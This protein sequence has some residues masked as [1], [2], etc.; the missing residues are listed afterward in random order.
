M[1]D[2]LEQARSARQ[3]LHS[4]E[5]L[6]LDD[7]DRAV[8]DLRRFIEQRNLSESRGVLD[9]YFILR[10]ISQINAPLVLLSDLNAFHEELKQLLVVVREEVDGLITLLKEMIENIA[11]VLT[12]QND[13]LKSRALGQMAE[14]QITMQR[15]EQKRGLLI[16]FLRAW[17]V[18]DTPNEWEPDTHSIVLHIPTEDRTLNSWKDWIAGVDGLFVLLLAS[19]ERLDLL[20]GVRIQRFE[21]GSFGISLEVGKEVWEHILA[22]LYRL[23]NA[24]GMELDNR[25]KETHGIVGAAN[26][27]AGLNRQL[28]A[29]EI[30]KDA[31]RAATERIAAIHHLDIAAYTIEVDGQILSD[32][33]PIPALN[34]PKE[35][36]ALPPGKKSRPRRRRGGK[37]EGTASGG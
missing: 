22:A 26:A 21:A 14:I 36:L 12:A 3:L 15:L 27:M 2:A 11:Q 4:T 5:D 16:S 20:D 34:P 24:R 29:G 30:G 37:P 33:R 35:Q 25:E 1:L 17:E 28:A 13:N 18:F 19:E 23:S 9:S 10:E 31:H 7:M 8:Q 6:R 32:D